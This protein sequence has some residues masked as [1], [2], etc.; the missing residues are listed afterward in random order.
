MVTFPAGVKFAIKKISLVLV[1]VP[2]KM[3]ALSAFW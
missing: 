2:E 1:L 3:L